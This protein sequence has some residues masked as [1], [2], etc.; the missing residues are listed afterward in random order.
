MPTNV[1]SWSCELDQEAFS[2]GWVISRKNVT[3]AAVNRIGTAHASTRLVVSFNG[4][5]SKS[6]PPRGYLCIQLIGRMSLVYAKSGAALRRQLLNRFPEQ[7][8]LFLEHRV[9]GLR[10]TRS[11]NKTAESPKSPKAWA[12]ST[13]RCRRKSATRLR[14]ALRVRR[15]RAAFASEVQHRSVCGTQPVLGAMDSAAAHSEGYSPR[16]SCTIRTARS[17]TSGEK[18]FDLLMASLFCQELKPPQY[19][20]RFSRHGSFAIR[21]F[22]GGRSATHLS[23]NF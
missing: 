21:G 23:E 4:W 10:A 5:S 16:C 19:P 12:S 1:A 22:A 8:M 17:R 13:C 2:R 18:W 20:G 9:C 15:D 3:V 6:I 14:A 11:K 7:S